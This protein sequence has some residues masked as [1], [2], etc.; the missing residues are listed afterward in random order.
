[1]PLLASGLA[2]ELRSALNFPAPTSD[3]LVGWAGGIVDEITQSGSATSRNIPGPHPISGLSGSSMANRV[4]SAAGYDSVSPELLDFC[5]AI[6]THIQSFGQ[7][8][9]TLPVPAPPGIQPPMA[10]FL[11]GTIT[12]LNGPLLASAVAAQVG[13]PSVTPQLLAKCT[14]LTNHIMLN[15]LVT[16]GVIA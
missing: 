6:S 15:A 12:G 14:A 3:Q 13:Y 2:D 1:M 8:F 11:N 9:Y 16:D 10:F 5:N 7:V 4:A